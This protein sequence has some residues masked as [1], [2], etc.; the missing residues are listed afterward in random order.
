MK[1]HLPVNADRPITGMKGPKN[2]P[3]IR[4]LGTQTSSVT[5]VSGI[6]LFRCRCECVAIAVALSA[7][8]TVM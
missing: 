6:L 3:I 4:S 7:A 2:A 5:N 1:G 8:V